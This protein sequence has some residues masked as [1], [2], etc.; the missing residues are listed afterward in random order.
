M[1][2]SNNGEPSVGGVMEKVQYPVALKQE[3]Q[4]ALVG[5]KRQ[6]MGTCAR[7]LLDI[8][9]IVREAIFQQ[10]SMRQSPRGKDLALNHRRQT[11]SPNCGIS[12]DLLFEAVPCEASSQSFEIMKL[13]RFQ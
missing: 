3:R 13:V 7:K 1:L 5:W 2:R 8:A 6:N 9:D 10:L 4:F 12:T 11:G